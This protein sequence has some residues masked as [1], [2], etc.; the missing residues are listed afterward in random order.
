MNVLQVVLARAAHHYLLKH[1]EPKSAILPSPAPA[2]QVTTSPRAG[3]EP[4][5]LVFWQGF[6]RKAARRRDGPPGRLYELAG[7]RELPI[8]RIRCAMGIN[9]DILGQR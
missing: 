1:G 9:R 4:K 6:P 2:I 3:S 7:P 5:I 8:L